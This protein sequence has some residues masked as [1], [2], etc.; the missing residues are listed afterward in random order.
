MTEYPSAL[1]LELL[2]D[3]ELMDKIAEVITVIDQK[4]GVPEDDR[5]EQELLEELEAEQV[6]RQQKPSAKALGFEN[7]YLDDEDE[8]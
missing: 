5:D 8:D 1:D 4:K 7:L 6:R 3:G 2:S